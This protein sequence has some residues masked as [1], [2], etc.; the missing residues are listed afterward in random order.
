MENKKFP[1]KEKS[2]PSTKRLVEG[3]DFYI[4][5][6]YYVFTALFLKNRGFCC[7]NGC[8]HCP[9]LQEKT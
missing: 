9:Y 2:T 3:V 1:K 7:K 5:H 6:G 8:R 4:A